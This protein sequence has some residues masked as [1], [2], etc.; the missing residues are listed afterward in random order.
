M[1]IRHFPALLAALA[2]LAP[3]AAAQELPA[4][5]PVAPTV[6]PVARPAPP[7]ACTVRS[8]ADLKRNPTPSEL[9]CRYRARGP[10]LFGL[11]SYLD[12]PVY[13]PATPL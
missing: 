7:N 10:G 6:A 12:V 8:I 4:A 1:M 13:Q 9:R 5:T 11:L 3:H 2:A